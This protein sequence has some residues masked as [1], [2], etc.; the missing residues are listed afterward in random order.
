MI[1]CFEKMKTLLTDKHFIKHVKTDKEERKCI[2]EELDRNIRD[3]KRRDGSIV[4]AGNVATFLINGFFLFLLYK[5][6]GN[7]LNLK[8]KV[9]GFFLF[10]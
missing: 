3:L 2:Q 5:N 1:D 8:V 10:C 9:M 6:E 7:N 4:F